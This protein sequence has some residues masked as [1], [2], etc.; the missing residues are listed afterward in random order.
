MLRTDIDQVRSIALKDPVSNCF[1]VSK[2][3][4]LQHNLWSTQNE[5]SV[6]ENNS[7]IES[8]LYNGA[9]IVPLRTSSDSRVAFAQYLLDSPKRASSIVGDRQE[10]LDLWNLIKPFWHKPREIRENQPLLVIDDAPLLA[11][12]PLVKPAAIR[13]LDLL[14]P[15][16]V[17]MF[18][19]EVGVSPV[20]GSSE[21]IYRAR[22]AEVI[23]QR[24]MFARIDQSQVT[25]KAEIGVSTQQVC[26]VQGVWVP[27]QLRGR[28]YGKAGM[29]AVV[30]L[31]R[32]NFAPRV[33]LYVNDYNERA[34]AV[35]KSVGFQEHSTFATVLF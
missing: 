28:N 24:K 25:F 31:T 29:A 32:K 9:N 27:P 3:E 7:V 17:S 26:Q 12:D 13:D 33:S 11:P 5:I 1:F 14:L 35:Y 6:F 2:L 30:D 10:V 8:A 19:E 34:R 18:T 21:Q 22:I 16:C 23:Q 15:A 4:D 20:L